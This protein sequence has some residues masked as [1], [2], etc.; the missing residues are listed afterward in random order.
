MSESKFAAVTNADD[1]D[2]DSV[3][4]AA[5]KERPVVVDF[6][7]PWC[8][9]CRALAPILERVIAEHDGAVSLVKVNVDEAP[10]LAARFQIQGI[11]LVVGFRDGKAVAEFEGAQ[12]ETVIR[13]FIKRVLPTGADNLVAAA[14]TLEARDPA[15]AE[16][17]YR[18]AL[19]LDSRHDAAALGLA[20]VLIDRGAEKEALTLMEEVGS[21]G[22]E[23][24]RLRGLAALRE[25]ARPF[26]DDG[27]LRQRLAKDAK[28]GQALFELGCVL[29]AQGKYGEALE[30]LLAAGELDPKLASNKVREAMVK[31]FHVIGDRSALADE[32]RQKLST[33][34]Y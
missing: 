29:A 11:P 30:N 6:W 18:E 5:S 23:A 7:A 31:I 34:L 1:T 17:Q 19:A 25:L 12:H 32:Y 15:A 16:K 8:G 26:A 10:A 2:F 4:I 24:E 20:R 3:V 21:A 14:K 27:T 13:D 9:P 33:L 22:E 28:N